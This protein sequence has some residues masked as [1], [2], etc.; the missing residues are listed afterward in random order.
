MKNT[1]ATIWLLMFVG[2]TAMGYE[3]GAMTCE[4]IGKFAETL[5]S[6]REKGQNKESALETVNKQEWRGDIEKNNMT[7]IVDLIHGRVGDQLANARAA[8]SIIKRDCDIGKVR[9]K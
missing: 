6:D 2:Q 1:A 3:T 8:Y 4:D 5:M 9:Q 7:S